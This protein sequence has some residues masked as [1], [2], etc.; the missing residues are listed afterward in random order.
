MCDYSMDFTSSRSAKPGERLTTT[1]FANSTTRGFAA[2]GESDVAVCLLP[3]TEVA[4]D[5]EVE[6]NRAF[7]LLPPLRIK[8]RVARFRRIEPDQADVHH[9]AL[10]FPTGKIVL[11]HRLCSGQRVTVLQLP[12]MPQPE[13]A[14]QVL[15]EAPERPD[16]V[17]VFRELR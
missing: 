5:N 6:Y 16:T 12:A 7:G 1:A 4:F 11:I 9:D 13:P 14:G 2:I 10:E 15:V 3:G 8:D 17:R